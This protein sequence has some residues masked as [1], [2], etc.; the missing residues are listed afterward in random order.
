MRQS[1]ATVALLASAV[2]GGLGLTPTAAHA[3]AG[4]P[5]ARAAWIKSCTD[6]EDDSSPCGRWQ[7][8]LR[9]G[10]KVTVR[11]AATRTNGRGKRVSDP[12]AFAISADGRVLAYERAGDHRLV[13]RRLAGGKVTVLPRSAVPASVG[14]EGVGLTLSPAGDKVLIDFPAEARRPAKVI[15]IATGRTV[16]LPAQDSMVGFSGDGGEVLA[17]RYLSDNTTRMTAYRLGGGSI[18]RTLPQVVANAAVTALAADGRTVAAFT[19]GDT[20]KG[21]PPRLR[22]HDL[23]TG[24]LSAGVDLPVK[25]GVLVSAA[26]WTAGGQLGVAV[27]S[28]EEGEPAVVRVLTVDP[29]SGAATRADSYTI[30]K[31]RY[32][33]ITA[34][35]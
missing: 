14:T 6:K 10:G 2:I 22:V 5:V 1:S 9:D 31:T 29:G 13:V 24:E 30:S 3:Q 11:G 25:A 12:G 34:G 7:V 19:P 33:F 35:E 27:Q 26:W 8:L 21:A 4:P 15:T 16:T 18:K 28:D 32:A 17:T 23:V 20:E